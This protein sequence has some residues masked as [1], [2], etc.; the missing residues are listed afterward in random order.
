MVTAQTQEK[1]NKIVLLVGR[2][3]SGKTW[4]ARLLA[5]TY[6]RV[7]VIDPMAEFGGGAVGS[8]IDCVQWLWRRRQHR[9]WS[10]IC[11]PT[12]DRD[13]DAIWRALGPDGWLCNCAVVVDEVDRWCTPSW[14]RA[15]LRHLIHYGRHR[16]VDLIA[17]ARRIANCSR[18]LSSQA[19]TIAAYCTTEPRDL[20]HLRAYMDTDGLDRLAVGEYRCGGDPI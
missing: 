1:R 5:A 11:R 9:T 3:G 14:T 18:D 19:D 8:G 16:R 6:R 17:S 13:E 20:A 7:V 12:G 10:C 2:K 4:K 15:E